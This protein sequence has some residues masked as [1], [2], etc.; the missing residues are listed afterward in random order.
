MKSLTKQATTMPDPVTNPETTTGSQGQVTTQLK[1][2]IKLV[3]I[4]TV[5]GIASF[6]MIMIFYTL[7][8]GHNQLIPN[9][10]IYENYRYV[11]K[12]NTYQL[13]SIEGYGITTYG[14]NGLIVNKTLNPEAKR[15]LFIGDSFVKAVQVSDQDK[16]TEVLEH[17][18]NS[19][20][21]DQPVQ[22]LNLGLGGQHI[23]TYLSFSQ[24]MDDYFQPDLVFIVLNRND[25]ENLA[26]EQAKL[27]AINQGVDKPL[28]EAEEMSYF[29]YAVNYLGVR[30]FFGQLQAQTYGFLKQQ[31]AS[32]QALAS[33]EQP[34]I[35]RKDDV[36]V[37]L[38]ALKQIWGQRLVII[39][40]TWFGDMAKDAP[41]PDTFEDNVLIE[42]E[43]Q[44]IPVIN[45]YPSFWNAF[46]QYKPPFGFDNSNLGRGHLNQYG[47][48]LVAQE[49]MKYLENRR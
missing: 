16:F 39:Y 20:H 17:E 12:P 49:I 5:S 27:T 13:S 41:S 40:V 7:L 3:Q 30:S 44:G 23:D 43:Q 47:H 36:A 25:F 21:P 19:L 26:D 34:D 42:L 4:W 28:V 46:K 14:E 2:L 29:E 11:G 22:S 45:L 32:N 35:L 24:N 10:R 37:Q 33:T 8:F 9:E 48:Y 1:K 6:L 38:K 31:N 18:W 15:L